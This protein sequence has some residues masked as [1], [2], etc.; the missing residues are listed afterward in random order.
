MSARRA[1]IL[2][3][4]LI[5]LHGGVMY[6]METR[7]EGEQVAILRVFIKGDRSRTE[8]LTGIDSLGE[9]GSRETFL[10]RLDKKVMWQL[11]DANR[12]YIET[13][14]AA[15]EPGMDDVDTIDSPYDIALKMDGEKKKILD[16][17]CKKVVL[18]LTAK[19][20]MAGIGITQVMWVAESLPGM[21]EIKNFYSQLIAGGG[22]PLPNSVPGMDARL[23]RDCALKII[24]LCGFPLEMELTAGFGTEPG[25][26]ITVK[27]QITKISE[28]PISDRVFD[29]PD[30]YAPQ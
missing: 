17:E 29:L 24:E 19:P 27:S 9:G 18:T 20:P 14:L 21:A 12:T 26:A 28:V 8:I 2:F 11:D 25:L 30:G 6:E 23:L 22:N 10:L 7:M 5:S 3:F 4:L 15:G 13:G 1:G 16:R